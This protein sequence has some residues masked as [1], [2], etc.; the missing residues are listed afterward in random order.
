LATVDFTLNKKVY[1][2]TK[3]L[4]YYGKEL[5]MSFEMRKKVKVENFVNKMKEIHEKAK[6]M[7]KKSQDKIKRYINRNRKKKVKYK[8]EN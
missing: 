2:V 7:L 1:L 5:R 8:M 3:L 4:L 6:A